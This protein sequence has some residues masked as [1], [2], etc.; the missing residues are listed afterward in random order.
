MLPCALVAMYESRKIR[1]VTFY[2]GE[3]VHRIFSKV[4]Q[5][6]SLRPLP[7]TDLEQKTNAMYIPDEQI[8]TTQLARISIDPKLVELAADVLQIL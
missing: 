3:D 8:P 2:G 4:P 1:P 6:G 5:S 7:K